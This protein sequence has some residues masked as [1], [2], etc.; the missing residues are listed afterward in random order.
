MFIP[1]WLVWVLGALL[2]VS[3]FGAGDTGESD[4]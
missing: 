4:E 2:I 3:I 1:M